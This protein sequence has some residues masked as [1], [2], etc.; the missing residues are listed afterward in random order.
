MFYPAYNGD[1]Q[2]LERLGARTIVRVEDQ[3]KL[4]LKVYLAERAKDPSSQA[5]KSS[6]SN[7]IALRHTIT[8]MYGESEVCRLPQSTFSLPQP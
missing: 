4:L 2:L 3:T 5:T 7:M 1:M 8:Q 6:R